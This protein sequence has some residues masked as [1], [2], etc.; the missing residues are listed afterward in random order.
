MNTFNKKKERE[1]TMS[2][3]L[4]QQLF[5]QK[6]GKE[7]DQGL[8][9]EVLFPMLRKQKHSPKE[10]LLDIKMT[11][12]SND[13]AAIIMSQFRQALGAHYH[14]P[15]FTPMVAHAPAD[16]RAVLGRSPGKTTSQYRRKMLYKCDW[17]S[18]EILN[19]L[20]ELNHPH[21]G[22]HISQDHQSDVLEFPTG[23]NTSEELDDMFIRLE[24]NCLDWS[25][26]KSALYTKHKERE[27]G[28]VND[29]L[30][31]SLVNDNGLSWG[32]NPAR[33]FEPVL[34]THY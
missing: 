30:E 4:V 27:K 3:C 23:P 5:R 6:I 10:L 15:P 25:L 12:C 16:R 24:E 33:P 13:G 29:F 26:A 9:E 20:R 11:Q 8:F 34:S 7:L 14:I 22:Y 28:L 31:D 2:P 1:E 32:G 18:I 21:I 19:E 17:G